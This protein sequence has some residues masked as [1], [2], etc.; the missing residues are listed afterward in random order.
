MSL[1]TDDALNVAPVLGARVR[2][3]NGTPESAGQRNMQQLIQLRW[4]A[5]VG[6]VAA[7]LAVHYGFG[8][9]LPLGPMLWLLAALAG[10]NLAS[11]AWWL[12]RSSVG[13]GAFLLALLV[14]MLTLTA[15]LGLSGGVTNP[16]LLLLLLQVALGAVLLRAPANWGLSLVA[17]LCVVALMLVPG[18]VRI[19]IH[20]E[21]GLADPFLQGLLVC[22]V[23]VAA[24]LV[25]FIARIGR[26][27]RNRDARLAEL[28]RQAVEEE[29]I[30]RIG[31]LASGA[32][33][34]L[35]TPLSTLSVILG[36][37][38]H[39]PHFSSDEDLLRDVAEMQSQVLRCKAIVTNILMSAGSARGEAPTET[40]LRAFFDEMA[41][42]W[43]ETRP[44]REF[45]YRYR[46]PGDL[47]IISDT[48][49]RQMV[50]NV[51]DNA[52]EASPDQVE[53][54]V[55][56][57]GPAL[58]IEVTDAGPGFPGFVLENLGKPYQSSKGR[59]GGGLGLFLS[60]NVARMFG[61]RLE[62]RNRDQGGASVTVLLP[63]QALMLEEEIDGT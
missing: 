47:A 60:I 5:V 39:S 6:Q 8:I 1:P 30:V 16:F 33:H 49:L 42:E 59:P 26:I 13:D 9:E 52:L 51:L 34:E 18:P 10:F 40:T 3:G 50:F 24:L 12:R 46:F 2:S 20:P 27:I 38:R 56:R 14:D 32:A 37:W 54:V 4:I 55:R 17:G 57:A 58:A 35:G 62:V 21:A 36:D 44:A 11:H 19:P 63:L 23:L 25:V 45:T 22:F 29:H 41:E 48:G 53:M 61:G 7:I 43:R 31:L 28:R 15:Q